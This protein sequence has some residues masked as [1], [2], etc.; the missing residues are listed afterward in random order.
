[1]P[2]ARCSGVTRARATAMS[3]LACLTVRVHEQVRDWHGLNPD[4]TAHVVAETLYQLRLLA[5]D[6]GEV[7]LGCEG[8]ICSHPEQLTWSLTHD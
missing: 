2:A 5:A 7:D 3:D 6:Y 4:A 8:L 1:M